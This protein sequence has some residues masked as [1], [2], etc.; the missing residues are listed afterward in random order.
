MNLAAAAGGTAARVAADRIVRWW[1]SPA[2]R[3]PVS[4]NMAQMA[5][6]LPSNARARGRGRRGRRGGGRGR[7]G[8]QPSQGVRTRGGSDIVVR[9]TEIIGPVKKGL[10]V[11]AFNPG[12]DGMVRLSAHEKMYGRYRT[13]YMNISYKSGSGTA[14]AGN[15]WVGVLI[16]AK[17]DSVT[18]G[19]VGRLRP[20]FYVP[21]WKNESLTLGRDIDMSR[22]MKCGDVTDDGTTFCLY[23]DSTADALGVLQCS[24]E[25]EFQQPRPF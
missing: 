24:Y 14:T 5:S 3:A 4:Y 19:S 23:V 22:W 20:S 6:A 10:T 21:A 15:V 13:R 11:Y 18:A 12:T 7:Q 9:D 25:V 8:G 2:P 1:E 16:G 17:N